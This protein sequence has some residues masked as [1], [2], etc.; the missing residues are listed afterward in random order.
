MPAEKILFVTG[1]LAADAL[2]QVVVPLGEQIG[3]Q[4]EI[5]V[6]NITVAA[7]MH[8]DWIARKLPAVDSSITR[9]LLPGWVQGPVDRLREQYG[10]PVELGPKDLFDLPEHFGR[11]KRPA[12]DLSR[13]DIEILAEINH[14]PRLTLEALL[15]EAERFRAAGADCI[16]LGCIPGERWT[17]I[18]IP[19]RELTARGMRVSVD[20]FD[21][22][23]V[24]LAV[25]AGAD[26]VFS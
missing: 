20:S 10:C 21:R 17:E 7:L 2:R 1:K 13:Y 26:L 8:V 4:P 9:I 16:D 12:A 11:G 24:E 18:S 23:E 5:A 14:A 22:D 25:A 19:V 6:L 15:A 3:F